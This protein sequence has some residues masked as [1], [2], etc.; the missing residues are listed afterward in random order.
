MDIFKVLA[1]ILCSLYIVVSVNGDD[2][3][4]ID[5]STTSPGNGTQTNPFQTIDAAVS[6]SNSMKRN[7]DKF[8]LAAGNYSVS[9]VKTFFSYHL[10]VLDH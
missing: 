6:F 9:N 2:C 8:C 3:L 5:A 10:I 4:Y 1:L 7:Q